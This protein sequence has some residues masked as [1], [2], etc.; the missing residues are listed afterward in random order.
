MKIEC[1]ARIGRLVVLR[2]LDENLPVTKTKHVCLCECGNEI[3]RTYQS[4]WEASAKGFDASCGCARKEQKPN[5]RHG[6]CNTPTYS[7]WESMHK[8]CRDLNNIY[9]GGRGV[10]VCK[11]WSGKKG[12]ENFRNDMGEKPEGKTLDKDIKG[13]RNCLLYSPENCCWAT[14][15][16]QATNR[17]NCLTEEEVS[18]IK[19]LHALKLS[20]R[21]I[22]RRTGRS[23]GTIT[24]VLER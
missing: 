18:A 5:L 8:R 12:F 21:E 24:S 15:K 16:E 10:K 19:S 23:R 3:I 13:G 11:R 14:P 7:C 17:N 9:Y 20:L 22:E 2:K 4:L 1:N 6:A